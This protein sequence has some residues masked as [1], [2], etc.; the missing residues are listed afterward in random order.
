MVSDIV[1]AAVTVI[2]VWLSVANETVGPHPVHV[3]DRTPVFLRHDLANTR[4]VL[5]GRAIAYGQ[6]APGDVAGEE[7][8]DVE[9]LALTVSRERR[10]RQ[11]AVGRDINGHLERVAA[12]GG[13]WLGRIQNNEARGEDLAVGDGKVGRRDSRYKE[14]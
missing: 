5:V 4:S 8:R 10:Q 12:E 13:V 3:L 7:H 1:G 11:L 14:R 9:D 2:I 6:V